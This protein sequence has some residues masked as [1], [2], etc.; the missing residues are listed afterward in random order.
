[1]IIRCGL[2]AF[3]H[4]LV[5]LNCKSVGTF[6]GFNCLILC[7]LFFQIEQQLTH[8]KIPPDE[9]LLKN[10]VKTPKKYGR[11]SK[12]SKSPSEQIDFSSN[13]NESEHNTDRPRSGGSSSAPGGLFDDQ[14]SP[15][16]IRSPMV[17]KI[18]EANPVCADCGNTDPE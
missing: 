13:D 5:S 8:G 4:V 1:M 16:T 7:L 18:L 3:G 11:N 9:M 6:D 14:Q 17:A 10:A 12:G 15:C 2:V